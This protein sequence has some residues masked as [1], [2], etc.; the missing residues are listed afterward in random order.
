M[1][2]NLTNKD[3]FKN[4]L[5]IMARNTDVTN[6]NIVMTNLLKKTSKTYKISA[7]DTYADGAHASKPADK[8]LLYNKEEKY[9]GLVDELHIAVGSRIMVRRNMDTTKGLINGSL[10]TITGIE[11]PMLNRDQLNSVFSS[12]KSLKTEND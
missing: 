8:K 12:I 1:L 5:Y 9:G 7:I 4:C 10:G 6:H 2:N 3:E 11:W